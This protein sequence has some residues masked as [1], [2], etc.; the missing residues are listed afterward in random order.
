[1]DSIFGI[2]LGLIA[3]AFVSMNIKKKDN[4]VSNKD[5]LDYVD[6][7]YIVQDHSV[8]DPSF[9]ANSLSNN[10]VKSNIN[11]HIKYIKYKNKY[12][13]EKRNMKG[14][15]FTPP[16]TPQKKSNKIEKLNIFIPLAEQHQFSSGESV[17]DFIQELIYAQ[18]LARQIKRD[19]IIT[20]SSAIAIVLYSL[21]LFNKLATMTKPSDF[22]FLYSSQAGSI[23]TK[24]RY[25]NIQ[26][27]SGDTNSNTWN[28]TDTIY[29][30]DITGIDNNNFN[31]SF[32][33]TI[34]SSRIK[35]LN[36]KSMIVD[37]T[38]DINDINDINSTKS[39]KSTED[40]E[41]IKEKLN[42]KIER[43][44]L[45]N[46]ILETIEKE[47]LE[48]EYGLSNRKKAR[49]DNRFN[50]ASL[51]SPGSPDNRFNFA[52]SESPDNRFNF[53]SSESPESPDNRFN[54]ASLESPGSPDNR[55]NF[56][57]LESQLTPVKR[58]ADNQNQQNSPVKKGPLF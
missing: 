52:S 31:N 14:G 3:V 48:E 9:G 27:K 5:K 6:K 17:E 44:K 19:I 36:L 1:M 38:N 29:T 11:Y 34:L 4:K 30:F 10:D 32:I 8:G 15:A 55:F 25:N 26:F 50:F 13:K 7:D 12:L 46:I 16:S 22:D 2:G 35:L 39:T 54:F 40:I 57:S 51:E 18:S 37:Y 28:I 49:P 20:G 42:R 53:A 56:A 43:L 33:L 41:S 47:N 58:S 45:L 24:Q 21:K 23:D